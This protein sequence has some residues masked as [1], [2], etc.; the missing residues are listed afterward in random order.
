MTHGNRSALFDDFSM[1]RLFHKRILRARRV[2]VISH[3]RS[4]RN[5]LRQMLHDVSVNPKYSHAGSKHSLQLHAD[6]ICQGIERY[7]RH[8]IVFMHRDPRDVL[9]SYFHQRCRKGAWDGDLSGRTGTFVEE[10]RIR[11]SNP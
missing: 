5:W 7:H 6:E 8:R 4:G 1:K 11:G 2:T 9:V 3:P 10:W